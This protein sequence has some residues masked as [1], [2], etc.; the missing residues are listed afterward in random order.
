MNVV[1]VSYHE[2]SDGAGKTG[3]Y[4]QVNVDIVGN[5]QNSATW[6]SSDIY[7]FFR[8]NALKEAVTKFTANDLTDDVPIGKR[9]SCRFAVFLM[10]LNP[11]W[12]AGG[13]R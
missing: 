2:R 3:Q 1:Q 10:C 6:V 13:P 11:V 4:C 12:L 8:A 7:R 9:R 5:G